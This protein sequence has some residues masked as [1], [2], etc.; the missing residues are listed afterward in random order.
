MENE[1][2]IILKGFFF[3][4]HAI[5]F[6]KGSNPTT[7]I[8]RVRILSRQNVIYALESISCYSVDPCTDLIQTIHQFCQHFGVINCRVSVAG[9]N[10]V[11]V[12]QSFFKF[13][14][15]MAII[16]K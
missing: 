6:L 7:K 3:A 5:V 4:F 1:L 12:C 9:A 10:D 15:D 13:A 11:H 8:D 16:L 2:N 14:F